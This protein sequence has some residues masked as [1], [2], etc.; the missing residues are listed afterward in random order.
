MTEQYIEDKIQEID[1]LIQ[2]NTTQSTNLFDVDSYKK[3]KGKVELTKTATGFLLHA[4]APTKY[5]GVCYNVE[6][7]PSTQYTLQFN[8]PRFDGNNIGNTQYA[9]TNAKGASVGSAI[10]G[11]GDYFRT[12]TTGPEQ[13]SITIHFYAAYKN[14]VQADI[15]FSDIMIVEGGKRDTYLSP[16]TF[17]DDVARTYVK[18]TLSA[19]EELKKADE[20]VDVS[21]KNFEGNISKFLLRRNEIQD[22]TTDNYEV[23]NGAY[24]IL[25]G[26][27][28]KKRYTLLSHTVKNDGF[29]TALNMGSNSYS[30]R[31][32]VNGTQVR[33]LSDLY[34]YPVYKGD[35]VSIDITPRGP[36]YVYIA[37]GEKT[38]NE[39]NFLKID[40][41]TCYI[42]NSGSNLNTGTTPFNPRKTPPFGDRSFNT[43]KFKGGE[44]FDVFLDGAGGHI[45]SY[46]S[47]NAI[48][49]S[50]HEFP[51]TYDEELQEYLA[52]VPAIPGFIKY[53]EYETCWNMY[54]YEW[55]TKYAEYYKGKEAMFTAD[56]C[57][58]CVPQ[59]D[60]SYKLHLKS[61]RTLTSIY[62]P[63]K[64][65]AIRVRSS[66]TLDHLTIRNYSGFGINV[67]GCSDA[68]IEIRDIYCEHIGG[69]F[70]SPNCRYGNGIQVNTAISN[71]IIE[72]CTVHDCF[73]TGI[74]IQGG[75]TGRNNVIRRCRCWSCF[76]AF[77][78]YWGNDTTFFNCVAYDSKD[79]SD[80][81]RGVNASTRN[82]LYLVWGA[83]KLDTTRST[84]FINCY[85]AYSTGDGIYVGPN[86]QKVI[87]DCKVYGTQKKSKNTVNT[88]LKYEGNEVKYV[89][90]LTIGNL[91]TQK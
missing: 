18:K 28:E 87:Q 8:I 85:G 86:V 89:E 30:S 2:V 37:I 68:H 90:A 71:C 45:T 5:D 41:H 15:E 50:L 33:G 22:T 63:T 25:V 16:K 56:N 39:F 36:H 80:G 82:S 35:K 70:Y 57:Y 29:L 4:M 67:Y 9:I 14:T 27:P 7:E 55:P 24:H 42:S 12:F 46:G 20:K 75:D 47:E 74:T 40:E 69:G 65:T 21:L 3:L 44:V 61:S 76:W 91:V 19:V 43:F 10:N 51:V 66:A 11:V 58:Y 84:K 6:V 23:K 52:D 31:I 60:G 77:E 88:I 49:D 26:G 62:A 38:S 53:S 17:L 59:D 32:F 1:H 72:D 54:G 13:T 48:F 79:M 64:A 34:E 83:G 81:Y 78:V 73:D